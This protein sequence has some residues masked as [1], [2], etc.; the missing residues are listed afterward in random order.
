MDYTP[1]ML[2][3]ARSAAP[4]R[5]EPVAALLRADRQRARSALQTPANIPR[6]SVPTHLRTPENTLTPH[7]KNLPR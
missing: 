4:L 3:V 6:T 2:L 5:S 7:A 1:L